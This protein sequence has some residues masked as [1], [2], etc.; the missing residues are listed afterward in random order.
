MH[1][2]S[3]DLFGLEG[4]YRAIDL[5]DEDG[6]TAFA[7]AMRSGL[8]HGAN[9]TMPHKEAAYRL[10]D[11]LSEDAARAQSV[12]TWYVEDGRLHGAS[13]DISGLMSVCEYRG[14]RTDLPV[15]VVGAGG[16]ARAAAVAFA[17]GEVR[18]MARRES[19][20]RALLEACGMPMRVVRW[21]DASEG[22]LVINCT[23]VG[24]R[25]EALPPSLSHSA[26][27]V[28]DMA[29]GSRETPLIADVRA[30]GLPHA[31]GIDVLA[32]QAA[33]AFAIW[34]GHNAPVDVMERAARN[35]SS[36]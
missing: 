13:T 2:A 15:T 28:I 5:P 30:R 9:I 24:M 14:I 4:V 33:H 25:G 23:P 36:E 27:A 17:D 8:V 10:A 31:D 3:L 18:V 32:A 16:A 20:A 7:T 1:N 35:A 11:E 29:Y 21:G 26:A 22:S 12:N 34:T 19:A 6:L